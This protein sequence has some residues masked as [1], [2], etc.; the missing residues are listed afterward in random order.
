[1][2]KYMFALVVSGYFLVVFNSFSAIENK[3]V[4]LSILNDTDNTVLIVFKRAWEA[5]PRVK[6][7]EAREAIDF[8]GVYEASVQSYS[9]FWG[10][11]APAK[12]AIFSACEMRFAGQIGM[13]AIR[14]KGIKG[15]T[16]FHPFGQ[17]DYDILPGKKAADLLAVDSKDIVSETVLDAFP[18][19][20]RKIMYTPRY[21]L[22]LPQNAG[23]DDALE[24]SALLMCK[25]R[26]QFLDMNGL[27][28]KLASNVIQIIDES[29]KAFQHG[30]ADVPL[31]IPVEM[32]SQMPC[33]A[34]DE[35]CDAI[36]WY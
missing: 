27:A 34:S 32:R 9:T 21:I 26:M 4:N 20:K 3:A 29:R 25:W 35:E 15:R 18:T 19:A 22:G 36:A 17:W 10:Y 2:N 24:A 30:Q 13:V 12:Q 16:L 14:I 7:L 1:M 6:L 5:M 31:H 11:I 23:F 8:G 33:S 28:Q